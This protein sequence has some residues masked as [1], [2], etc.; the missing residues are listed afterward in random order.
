MKYLFFV[1]SEGRG[2]LTQALSV[3]EELRKD[4]HEI[5]GVVMNQNPVRKI[6]DFFIE[7]IGAPINYIKSPYFLINK[8]GTGI[9]FRKSIFFNIFRLRSY[10]KSLK[11]IHKLYNKYQPDV[12]INFFEPLAGLYNLFFKQKAPCFS[13]GH[14]FFAEH[15]AFERP[16]GHFKDYEYFTFYNHLTSY[17]SK[18]LLALS[19]TEELD[20]LDRKLIICPPLIRRDVKNLSPKRENFIL[21]YMLNPGSFEEI[22]TWANLHPEQRIEAFWDK[23]GETEVKKFGSNLKF[24]P[25]S[26]QKFL[27]LLQD[28][29]TYISTGGFE[30]ICEAAY[31]QKNI[32]MVPTKNHYEQLCNA[33]DAVRAKLASF[34]S[35][36]NIDLA[37]ANQK[38]HPEEPGRLFKEWV[39]N[40]SDKVMKVIT[41]KN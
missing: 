9:D 28:C 38:N 35:F 36:F 3:S 25:I 10:I 13:I 20:I 15:P 18:A 31:L 2:H 29:S 6:P 16:E 32:L 21:S 23:K 11:T 1:Q 8:E 19:F 22:K 41:L 34:D 5:V 40:N 4:G 12:V 27:D 39:D 37:I 24:H 26:G 17:G 14:Q 7:D 33:H 30:S